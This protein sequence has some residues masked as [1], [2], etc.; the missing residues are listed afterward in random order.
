[1]TD[2]SDWRIAT[3]RA[4]RDESP[5]AKTFTFEL[6]GEVVHLPGQHYE[7]RLTAED[8]YQAARLYSAASIANE[9]RLLELTLV[10]VP[11]GE[12]T[13]YM[14]EHVGVGDQVEIRGPLGK[15]FVWHATDSAPLLL[16]GG[17]SGV[18]PLRCILQA[19]AQ[20]D[21]A[22]PV[23]LLYSSRS[24]DDIIYKPE[25]LHSNSVTITL[26]H[27][28]SADWQG[29]VGLLDEAALRE[30]LAN[31]LEVPMCYVCGRT[32]FV[33]AMSDTLVRIGVPPAR[34]KAERFGA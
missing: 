3:V 17:G 30:A 19:H 4:I 34:I 27:Q 13:P 6:P 32:P 29:H 31:L 33:E 24:Y 1:M 21:S 8:G 28:H 23:R 10:L 14:F 7:I 5:T 12:L 2:A 15:F 25:L 18:V 22:V 16:I 26:T 20:A 11:D 9:S